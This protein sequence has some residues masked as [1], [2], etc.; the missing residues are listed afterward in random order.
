MILLLPLLEV[1]ADSEP[2]HPYFFG[3][4]KMRMNWWTMLGTKL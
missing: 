3:L 2:A 1:K 4:W